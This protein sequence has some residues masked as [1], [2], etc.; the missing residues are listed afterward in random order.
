MRNARFT[1]SF[2]CLI[3]A[4]AALGS[5]AAFAQYKYIGPDGRVV[6]S[7][8]PPPPSAKPIAKPAGSGAAA[9]AA[10]ASTAS[11]A[12]SAGLPYVLQQAVKTF[13]VTL[14]TT[15]ECEACTQ[16]RNY[17]TKRGVPFTEKTVR[18]ADDLKVFKEATGAGQVPVMMLGNNKQVGFEEGAWNGALN[19]AGYPP[20]NLLPASYKNPPAAPSAPFTPDSKT[21]AAPTAPDAPGA[22]PAAGNA[23]APGNAPSVGSTPPA[24]PA[25]N[26]PSWFKGF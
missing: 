12:S 26:R 21:A 16:G 11:S 22:P 10:A 14:Y 20:N 6:Y 18:N 25:A 5:T 9:P 2:A 15:N 19:V 8:Q 17:L 7:D 13:P 1:K 4:L 24:D 3:A 23:P